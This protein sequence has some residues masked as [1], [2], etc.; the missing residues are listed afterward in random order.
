MY[1]RG[2]GF[3]FTFLVVCTFTFLLFLELLEREVLGPLFF[4][5]LKLKIVPRIVPLDSVLGATFVW[6]TPCYSEME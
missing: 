6:I 3:L 5:V 2:S 1:V 4:S